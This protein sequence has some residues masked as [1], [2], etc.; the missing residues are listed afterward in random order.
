VTTK[1]NPARTWTAENSV[2]IGGAYMCIYG[3]EGPGGYQFVGR[4]IQVW[5]TH[6]TTADFEKGKPWLLRFFDQVRFYPVGADE[7][8]EF[9]RNFALGRVKLNIEQTTFS[10]HE[11]HQ[12]LHANAASIDAFRTTQR[13]AFQ[14]ERTRWEAAGEFRAAEQAAQS[15]APVDAGSIDVPDGAEIVESPMVAN[16]WK[17]N[18]AANQE[19]RVGDVLVILEAMKMEVNI[20]APADGVVLSVNCKPGQM[21]MPGAPLCVVKPG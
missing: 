6:K 13:R 20:T 7:L 4:T 11:Y 15:D 16:V 10:L 3:M 12:F 2:G 21:V 5:N 19:V 14:E 17:V 1:Y 18:V 8:L 9:R